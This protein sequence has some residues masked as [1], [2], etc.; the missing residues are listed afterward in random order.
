MGAMGRLSE[1]GSAFT[2]DL[3]HGP[4]AVRFVAPAAVLTVATV[5]T[6][7]VPGVLDSLVDAAAS[8]LDGQVTDV[9]LAV[10]HGFNRPL[11]WS[12]VAIA[13]GVL[14]FGDAARWTS[15]SPVCSRR[16]SRRAP[17]Y[18]ASL[19]GLNTVANKVTGVVQSGSLPIYLGVILL[20]AAA[21]PGALLLSGTWWPGW[22]DLVDTPMQA[23]IA[24]VILGAAIAAA[25][26]RRRFT[27]ALFLGVVG[28]SMA[29]LFVIQ[30]APDLAL[31]QVAI[32]SLT[33]VLFVL[34]LRR[35]PDRFESVTPLWRR[36]IRVGIAGLVGVTVFALAL[37]AGCRAPPDTGIRRD[38]RPL[39][40][41]RQRTQRGERHPGRVP[42]LRHARRDHRVGRR[43]HRHRRARSRR[44]TALDAIVARIVAG[45]VRRRRP[46][47][48]PSGAGV[49][50]RDARGVD[51]GRVRDRDGRVAVSPVRRPQPAW[52]RIRRRHRRRRRDRAPLHQRRHRRGATSCHAGSHG[53]CSAPGC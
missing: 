34:V 49:Q 52:R 10:W 8:S 36:G 53:S 48:S 17:T 40:P 30:G 44:T 38:G 3:S 2:A 6:G 24:A 9:H 43:G 11:V 16:R 26:V 50:A 33:T 1:R 22:P 21:V 15:C 12:I 27:A 4:P 45:F 28:Y 46:R 31:T 35:L 29:G 51:A 41:R 47:R 25:G 13:A 42:R 19:R 18:R 14:L 20:T 23:P 7:V 39:V 32:E 37:S 5:F